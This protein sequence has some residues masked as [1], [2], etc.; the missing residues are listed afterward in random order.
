MGNL[1]N[2]VT[3]QISPGPV[4]VDDSVLVG[5]QLMRHFE[6]E[7]PQRF[8][9]FLK[10]PSVSD[11]LNKTVEMTS[12]APLMFDE[13]SEM[14]ITKSNSTLKTRIHDDQKFFLLM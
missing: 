14:H 5:G 10:K 13:T 9:K 7:W 3:G 8:I 4:N 11:D 6:D 12:S 2:L 1:I